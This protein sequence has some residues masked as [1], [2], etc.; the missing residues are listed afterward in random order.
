MKV[1]RQ[2]VNEQLMLVATLSR[3]QYKKF[4]WI[5]EV[6]GI[7]MIYIEISQIVHLKV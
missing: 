3:L 1:G 6:Y 2:S 4:D 5:F 7:I